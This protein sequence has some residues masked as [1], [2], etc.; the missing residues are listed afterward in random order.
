MPKFN[1][2]EGRLT[3]TAIREW[4]LSLLFKKVFELDEEGM[5]RIGED[6]MSIILFR[7][8]EDSAS[9]LS[10]HYIELAESYKQKK[11]LWAYTNATVENVKLMA[12]HAFGL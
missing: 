10:K 5:G 11:L 6:K 7:S 12:L 4:V 8:E 1:T 2:F 9:E 3:K